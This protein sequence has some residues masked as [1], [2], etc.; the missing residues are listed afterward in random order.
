MRDLISKVCTSATSIERRQTKL[1]HGQGLCNIGLNKSY[2]R[3]IGYMNEETP[4]K[5]YLIVTTE[6]SY[7][8]LD[9]R[10]SNLSLSLSAVLAVSLCSS[11]TQ[12]S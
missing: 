7:Q 3:I 4:S 1:A 12:L 2:N 5:P 6:E 11:S 8:Q 10:F 9:T